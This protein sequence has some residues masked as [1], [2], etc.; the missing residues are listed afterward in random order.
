MKQIVVTGASGTI[1]GPLLQRLQQKGDAV[2]AVSRDE[3]QW[4]PGVRH[5]KIENLDA[6]TDWTGILRDQDVLVHLAALRPDSTHSSADY[7]RVNAAGTAN[8]VDQAAA[9]GVGMVIFLS[10]I[11]AVTA[12]TNTAIVTDDTPQVPANAYGRSKLAGEN[13]VSRFASRN[14]IGISLRPPLVYGAT[15]KGNWQ[16]ML[17]LA[18]SRMLL[19]LGAVNNRRT[20]ISLDNLASAILRVI[21]VAGPEKSGAYAVADSESVSLEEMVRYLREGM[22]RR[23]SMFPLPASLLA[24]ALRLAGK[25]QIADSLLGNLEVDSSRFRAA[26]D[27]KPTESA[28]DS[29]RRSGREYLVIRR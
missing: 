20:M 28:P 22:G 6:D 13:A 3:G 1:G 18:S 16:S 4:P 24:A 27:W 14:R 19:P 9:C 26:F 7:E 17:K 12:N 5:V 23:A 10:S 15:A 8:I 11:A 29:I 21:E 25:R 2:T